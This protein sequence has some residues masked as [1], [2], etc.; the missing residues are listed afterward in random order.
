MLS[1][2]R[3]A[4]ALVGTAGGRV[5]LLAGLGLEAL[6]AL[7][8]RLILKRGADAE[9]EAPLVADL[10]AMALTAGLTPHLA[11]GVVAGCVPPRVGAR[12]A[13]PL[14]RGGRLVDALEAE[15]RHS[16]ELEP[17]LRTLVSCERFGAPA[18]PGLRHLAGE[19]R[20]RVRQE[21]MVRARRASVHLLFPLVFL[22]LPAFLVL[23]TAPVLLAGF[24]R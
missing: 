24:T 14:G 21:A 16:P 18:A 7:W 3:V 13:A 5:C 2:R 11:L 9:A 6:A 15:A 23:T 22:V 1:D 19:G 4:A 12:L 10:L 20:A 17:V 8:M